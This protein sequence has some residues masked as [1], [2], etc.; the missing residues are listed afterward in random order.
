MDYVIPKAA[1]IDLGVYNMQG[2]KV[3]NLVNDI[4]STGRHRVVWNAAGSPSGVYVVRL[5]V[6]GQMQTRKILLLK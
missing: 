2:E 3:A 5:T 6:E 4:R 1:L